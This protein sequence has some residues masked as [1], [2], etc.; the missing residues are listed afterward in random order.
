MRRIGGTALLLAWTA[1]QVP[2]LRCVS[3]CHDAIVL[4]VAEHDHHEKHCHARGP[5]NGAVPTHHEDGHEHQEIRFE[6]PVPTKA[7]VSV[8]LPPVFASHP[9]LP[10]PA[11]LA[12]V[13]APLDAA[14]PAP[15]PHTV[16]LLL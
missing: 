16:V 6:A 7:K 13:A 2:W 10:A 12:P 4:A 11:R 9:V 15:P 3:D 14:A 1:L 8:A 5:S